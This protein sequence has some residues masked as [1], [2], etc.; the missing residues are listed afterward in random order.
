M[1]AE[2]LRVDSTNGQIE[3]RFVCQWRRSECDAPMMIRDGWQR[4]RKYTPECGCGFRWIVVGPGSAFINRGRAFGRLRRALLF[5]KPG[6]EALVRQ[7]IP[8]F[9]RSADRL[10]WNPAR[11]PIGVVRAGRP[12]IGRRVVPDRGRGPEA[13]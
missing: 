5:G 13:A 6:A 10:R 9:R 7:T 4:V 8:I 12:A 11:E 1:M 2:L 3:K